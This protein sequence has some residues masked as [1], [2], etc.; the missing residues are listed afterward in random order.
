MGCVEKITYEKRNTFTD[1][2][3]TNFAFYGFLSTMSTSISTINQL[4]EEFSGLALVPSSWEEG[5]SYV[6]NTQIESYAMFYTQ[7]CSNCCCEN[8]LLIHWLSPLRDRNLEDFGELLI[9]ES[10]NAIF[11][12]Q[13]NTK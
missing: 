4:L 1:N 13:E 5:I 3:E 12:A 8:T 10:G 7:S 11:K 2:E 9:Y 6:V